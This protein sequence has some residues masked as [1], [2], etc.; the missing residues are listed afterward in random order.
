MFCPDTCLSESA[1][2]LLND[3]PPVVVNR[4]CFVMKASLRIS[5]FFTYH[6]LTSDGKAQLSLSPLFSCSQFSFSY[7][8]VHSVSFITVWNHTPPAYTACF[9]RRR[10]ASR[11]LQRPR[12]GG[13]AVPTRTIGD[14]PAQS[15]NRRRAGLASHG[16]VITQDEAPFVVFFGKLNVRVLVSRSRMTCRNSA[17]TKIAN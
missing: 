15:A 3:S 7:Y 4:F 1:R 13:S 14:S 12:C 8:S 5:V 10:S 6:N 17:G 16:R 2:F 9:L 11:G